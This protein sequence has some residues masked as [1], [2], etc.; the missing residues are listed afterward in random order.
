MRTAFATTTLSPTIASWATCEHDMKRQL[1][2]TIVWPPFSV[3]R[4]IVTYSRMTVPSPTLTPVW[5]DGSNLMTWGSPPT[6]A[7]GCTATRSPRIAP[8]LMMAPAWMT[9]PAPSLAPGST[10]A[11]GWMS[12]FIVPLSKIVPF[13][14]E[15]VLSRRALVLGGRRLAGPGPP[16]RLHPVREQ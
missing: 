11:V 3:E 10:I 13:Q 16:R 15:N 14:R 9:Q 7:Y 8:D 5:T 1:D 2:P 4:L 6:T 12:F